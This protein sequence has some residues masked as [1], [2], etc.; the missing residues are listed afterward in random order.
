M[1][2]PNHLGTILVRLITHIVHEK[3]ED[4][5]VKTLYSHMPRLLYYTCISMHV[6]F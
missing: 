3:V 2:S 5:A 6:L 4:I 1:L